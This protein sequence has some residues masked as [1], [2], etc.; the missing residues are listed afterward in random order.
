MATEFDPSDFTKL[1]ASEIYLLE[2]WDACSA[3]DVRD[4]RSRIF[5]EYVK[6]GVAGRWHYHEI[7]RLE[8]YEAPSKETIEHILKSIRTKDQRALA[9]LLEKGGRRPFLQI[10]HS[11]ISYT[12]LDESEEDLLLWILSDNSNNDIDILLLNCRVLYNYSTWEQLLFCIPEVVD[13]NDGPLDPQV[14]QSRVDAQKAHSLHHIDIDGAES[15]TWN[16]LREIAHCAWHTGT[17]WVFD[18]ISMQ[19]RGWHIIWMD[20]FGEI[21][22]EHR[23]DIWDIEA[24]VIT[25]GWQTK[26]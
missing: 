25:L 7:A 22:R 10:D 21:I 1:L 12:V 17:L 11:K 15:W 5:G 13:G 20:E 2:K 23:L 9:A 8:T 19:E 6:L 24:S 4:R 18:E 26:R 14:Y 3:E 16:D